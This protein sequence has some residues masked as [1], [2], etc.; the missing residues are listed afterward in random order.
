MIRKK[1]D[2]VLGAEKKFVK[3]LELGDLKKYFE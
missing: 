1:A 2:S 3:R